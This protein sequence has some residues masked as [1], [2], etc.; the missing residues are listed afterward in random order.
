MYLPVTWIQVPYR[1]ALIHGNLILRQ[2]RRCEHLQTKEIVALIVRTEIIKKP[3]TE[4]GV[5]RQWP[6]MGNLES[7]KLQLKLI[8]SRSHTWMRTQHGAISNTHA[9]TKHNSI[10]HVPSSKPM[11]HHRPVPSPSCP[12]PNQTPPWILKQEQ[13]GS[14]INHFLYPFQGRRSRTQILYRDSVSTRAG[15]CTRPDR[16]D[17]CATVTAGPS[18]A[19]QTKR[20][21]GTEIHWN[22]ARRAVPAPPWLGGVRR[23]RAES[24]GGGDKSCGR[25]A[26]AQTRRTLTWRCVGLNVVFF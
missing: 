3:I 19:R 11:A 10:G 4:H 22:S 9:R 24:T 15:T 26:T 21:D 18:E 13:D 16:T 2:C 1:V 7:G 20:T 17:R 12:N 6:L 8:V 23:R 25:A 14:Q 5:W